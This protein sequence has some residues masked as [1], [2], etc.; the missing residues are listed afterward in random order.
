MTTDHSIT[1]DVS[2]E[3]DQV[4]SI[5]EQLLESVMPLIPVGFRA[6]AEFDFDF[7]A[8]HT[9]WRT[10]LLAGITTFMT[11]AYIIFVNPSILHETAP[12]PDVSPSPSARSFF[13][14]SSSSS[15]PALACAR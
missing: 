7:A 1:S 6:R 3:P 14:A 9:N 8:L 2:S 4:T 13:P 11:M 5:P 12:P 10:E 15:S